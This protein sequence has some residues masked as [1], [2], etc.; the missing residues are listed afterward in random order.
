MPVEQY[1]T[2]VVI[3]KKS[4]A[5]INPQGQA[6]LDQ[7]MEVLCRWVQNKNEVTLTTPFLLPKASQAWLGTLADYNA[8]LKALD[9]GQNLDVWVVDAI[10]Y[11]L[12]IKGRE[13]LFTAH[14]VPFS[15]SGLQ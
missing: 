14:L 4:M 13:V 8:S 7:P 1:P 3:F 11:G 12:D 5:G 9:P 6:I 10:D 2:Q 15:T